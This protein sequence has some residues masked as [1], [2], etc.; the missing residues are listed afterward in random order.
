VGPML[1]QFDPILD[2]AGPEDADAYLVGA[3]A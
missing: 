1:M 3:A 2:L